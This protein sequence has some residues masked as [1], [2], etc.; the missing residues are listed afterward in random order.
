MG[1]VGAI[2]APGQKGSF[3]V[4]ANH[5]PLIANLTA[6]VFTLTTPE[7]TKKS[8]QIGEGFLDVLKNKV[9]LLTTSI[10]SFSTT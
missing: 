1:E 2:V 7:L 5:A 6:G 3:G 9:T 8:Y 10:F 4:L